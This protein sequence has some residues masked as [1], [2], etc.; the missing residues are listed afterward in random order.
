VQ[1]SLTNAVKHS[2]A[3]AAIWVHIA[4][5]DGW[6]NVRVH[7]SGAGELEPLETAQGMACSACENASRCCGELYTGTDPD[8]GFSSTLAYRSLP[9]RQTLST[10]SHD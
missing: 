8:G 3:D 7:D 1:E 6:V 4:P 5:C 9:P 2:A 10:R